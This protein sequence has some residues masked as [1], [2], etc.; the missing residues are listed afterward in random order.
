MGYSEA[1]KDVT[2]N[3]S[4]NNIPFRTKENGASKEPIKFGDVISETFS[5]T[6]TVRSEDSAAADSSPFSVGSAIEMLGAMSQI[7]EPAFAEELDSSMEFDEIDELDRFGDENAAEEDVFDFF[8]TDEASD[9][10]TDDL[11]FSIFGELEEIG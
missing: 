11:D 5:G 1:L 8:G 2:A 9:D 7:K 4:K 6:D 10:M 3:Y